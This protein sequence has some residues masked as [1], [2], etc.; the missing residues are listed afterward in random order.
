MWSGNE[1]TDWF[2]GGREEYLLGISDLNERALEGARS[3]AP[4]DLFGAP[5]ELH[6]SWQRILKPFPTAAELGP[7]RVRMLWSYGDFSLV[8]RNDFQRA[9]YLLFRQSWRAR[10]C[11]RCKAFFVARRPKQKFCGTVCSAG[12]RLA[13]KRKWWRSRR[14]NS[15]NASPTSDP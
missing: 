11:P 2:G 14:R 8:P 6:E 5:L 15:A 12:S 10:A 7:I 4:W 1:Q 13:S 3:D 9:F